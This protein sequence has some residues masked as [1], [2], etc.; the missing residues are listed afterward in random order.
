MQVSRAT[1]FLEETEKGGLPTSSCQGRQS[2]PGLASWHA[3]ARGHLILVKATLTSV[4]RLPLHGSRPPLWVIKAIDKRR[5]AFLWKGTDNVSGGHSLVAWSLVCR[6]IE[7]G[8]LGLHNLRL[9]GN[10]LHIR[11]LWL[12]KA[13][14]SRPCQGLP[15]STNRMEWSMFQ[16][17]I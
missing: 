5:R 17:S 7:H 9:L 6:P 8:G 15:I 13:R 10:A 1:P 11:W 2:T 3:L 12:Q 4:P 14:P 16:A